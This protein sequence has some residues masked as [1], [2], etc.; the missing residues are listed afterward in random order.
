MAALAI[1]VAACMFA[2]TSPALAAGNGDYCFAENTGTGRIIV[3]DSRT[4]Q[5]HDMHP[6][7]ASFSS[8]W[9][10]HYGFGAN[11]ISDA[12]KGN[13]RELAKKTLAE[14][15]WCQIFL[16]G[17][18][19][20]NNGG[21]DNSAWV[22]NLLETAR[23]LS[24]VKAL[25]NGQDATCD[26]FVVSN[27]AERGG[28]DGDVSQYN[29]FL[30]QHA[31]EYGAKYIDINQLGITYQSDGVHFADN[32]L[33]DIWNVVIGK[34][35]EASKPAT[36]TLKC[37]VQSV[38]QSANPSQSR[39]Q[40]LCEYGN[41]TKEIEY[42]FDVQLVNLVTGDILG[43]SINNRFL[44]GDANGSRTFSFDIP[45]T[46]LFPDQIGYAA[47]IR[48]DDVVIATAQNVDHLTIVAFPD[49]F[50]AANRIYDDTETSTINLDE[51]E[52]SYA[53]E[54]ERAPIPRDSVVS[55]ILQII[56][57]AALVC[58][59][60]TAFIVYRRRRS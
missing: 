18:I 34:M 58:A 30:E 38:G 33:Q 43:Q 21:H 28:S 23:E 57:S 9:G 17:T 32:T 53:P 51:H 35:S 29:A 19:N 26:V 44:A 46:T 36:A 52:T 40:V 45:L 60:G 3:G 49:M 55:G 25:Y 6:D 54:T 24:G 8:V 41:L 11:I 56:G 14:K 59:L 37:A 2:S 42:A 50:F 7:Q 39:V 22:R 27:V 10:G 16:F 47:E 4:Y 1:A 5:M 48:R 13:I 12:R 20:D 31:S 15:G